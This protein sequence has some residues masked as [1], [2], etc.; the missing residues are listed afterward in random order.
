[1]QQLVFLFFEDNLL[2]AGM[3]ATG[4]GHA[5]PAGE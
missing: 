4:S 2:P 3:A 1:M 5:R